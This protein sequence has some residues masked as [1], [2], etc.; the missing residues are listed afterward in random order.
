[1]IWTLLDGGSREPVDD[2]VHQGLEVDALVLE[3]G[4]GPA[5]APRGI[6]DREVELVVVG[7]ELQ[8]Q[9]EDL[10]EDLVRALAA[11]AFRSRSRSIP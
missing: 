6:D 8:E 11:F 9:V 3:F 2:E 7:V 10:I 5:I 4:G 1:M